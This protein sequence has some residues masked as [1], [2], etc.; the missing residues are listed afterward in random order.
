[1]GNVGER[2][3][4]WMQLLWIPVYGLSFLMPRDKKLWLFGS[5]FGKRFADNPRYFYLYL[6]AH[7]EEG[8]R[9]VWISHNREVVNFLNLHGREAYYLRSLKGMWYCLRGGVYLYDNYS[10]DISHWLSGGAVKINLWHGTGNKKANRDNLFDR[11]RHPRNSREWFQTFPRRLSDEK[12]NHYTLA[13]S[14]P[15]AV[16][17]KS[18]FGSRDMEHVI[19]DGYPRNDAML[20]EQFPNLCSDLEKRTLER[21]RKVKKTGGK[22]VF[23]MPT[24]RESEK[25]LLTVMDWKRFNKFLEE[26]KMV[27][28]IKL[29]PKSQIKERLENITYSCIWSLCAEN[30][31]YTFLRWVDVLVTDYSS[32]YS[33]YML[34]DRPAVAFRYDYE[35]YKANTRD[36]YIPHEEY[37]PE[38]TAYTMEELEQCLQRVVLE[39]ACKEARKVS[40]DRMFKYQDA[41]ASRR[42]VKKIKRLTE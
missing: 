30:D 5:T 14:E 16:I 17:T 38:L 7:P 31:P 21:I 8:V 24:F 23:Y 39:D 26:Q 6:S 40:R 9:P 28:V 11:V 2:I 1:M 27:F 12:P 25:E 36:S 18:A 29:H 13:T 20:D 37:M 42:L 32:V 33:D 3:K 4:Y 15:L 34:L 10:K 41:G 19:I 22:I 35:T